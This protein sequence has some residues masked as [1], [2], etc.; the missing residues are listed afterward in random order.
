MSREIRRVPVDFTW[1]L[2]KT[3]AGYL[4]PAELRLPECP[5]CHRGATPAAAWLNTLMYRL[6]M[7]ADDAAH[8]QPQGRPLHPWLAQDTHPPSQPVTEPVP[9]YKRELARQIV[10]D[11]EARGEA[12]P[13]YVE[14]L[15]QDGST[16]TVGHETLRP[17]A[18]IIDLVVGLSGEPRERL[19]RF[20]YHGLEHRMAKA[21]T[22]AAGL[23]DEW[24]TCATC[25]GTAEV[26]TDD[27]RAAAEAWQ[28]TDPPE[29]DGW[30]LWETVSEGSPVSPV[31]ADRAGLVTWLTTDYRTLNDAPLTREQ[32]EAFVTAGS[33]IGTFVISNRGLISGE[34]AVAE[35]G[36]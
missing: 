28:R 23:G 33:S 15:A 31:F 1:P 35:V 22:D 18:D 27:Q 20:G 11:A 34:A 24:G 16:D 6:Q 17:G 21:V 29:G 2:R 8:T 4:M 5:D 30:Q 13:P 10:A 19:D 26:A 25:L 12:A 7:L 14:T 32:A 3:W 36:G 9:Q